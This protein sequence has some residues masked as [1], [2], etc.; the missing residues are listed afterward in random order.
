MANTGEA[1]HRNEWSGYPSS[2]STSAA[3][4]LQDS[5]PSVIA[6]KQAQ[7]GRKE[8]EKELRENICKD[9]ATQFMPLVVRRRSRMPCS[10]IVF[11]PGR[12]SF[13]SFWKFLFLAPGGSK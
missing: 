10:N 8:L 4:D 6:D 3:G 11:V 1:A 9:F 7:F 13:V 12:V 2:C 5:L